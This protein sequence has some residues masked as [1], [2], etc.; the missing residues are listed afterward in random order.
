[1]F[2]RGR[3]GKSAWANAIVNHRT[4]AEAAVP[5]RTSQRRCQCNRMVRPM[6]KIWARCVSPLN[7][8]PVGTVRVMLVEDMVS[9]VPK[10]GPIDVI[11]PSPRWGEMVRGS[12]GIFLK[13]LSQFL[14]TLDELLRSFQF[15]WSLWVHSFPMARSS[16]F[17][18]SS[19]KFCYP[20]APRGCS[21]SSSR[22]RGLH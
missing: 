15:R 12:L 2:L 4:A 1:M 7:P 19:H 11:H 3:R 21:P 10:E 13:L 5:I 17:P 18:T 20:Y 6:H 16:A 14:C 8:F 22:W 9:T